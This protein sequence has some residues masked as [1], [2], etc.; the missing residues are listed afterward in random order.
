MREILFGIG[1]A[2][3]FGFLPFAV[4]DMPQW[5]T[6]PGITIGVC[7]A[8]WGMIPEG[9]I[10]PVAAALFI[11]GATFITTAV[12]W[13]LSRSENSPIAARNTIKDAFLADYVERLPSSTTELSAAVTSNGQTQLV[14]LLVRI[15]YD[16]DAGTKFMAV[17]TPTTQ[18]IRQ[19]CVAIANSAADVVNAQRAG[20]PIL[21]QHAGETT[22]STELKFSG[23][24][25]LYHE[26]LV[27]DSDRD[28]CRN[29]C[30]Q[31]GL[32]L[33]FRG[34]RYLSNTAPSEQ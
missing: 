10:S 34:S 22:S 3:V 19:I 33:I 12:G 30:K 17:Y 16:F 31:K 15:Y 28:E 5:M 21:R 27:A 7:L 32:T 13:Q 4:K 11:A 25:Y 24:I 6:W 26:M 2:A 20:E 29:Y 1:V 8:I 14:P 9:K 18:G 23:H